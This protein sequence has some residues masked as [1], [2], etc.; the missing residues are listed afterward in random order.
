M[1]QTWNEEECT[2][3]PGTGEE[4]RNVADQETAPIET[5]EEKSSFVTLKRRT[6]QVPRNNLERGSL[7][8]PIPIEGRVGDK[9]PDEED[10]NRGTPTMG[11][12]SEGTSGAP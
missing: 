1:R 11:L 12:A 9:T 2:S 10:R 3:S 6:K 4:A 8:T 7:Q 5:G